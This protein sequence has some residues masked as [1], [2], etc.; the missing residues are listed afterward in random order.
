MISRDHVMKAEL[1]EHFK[2]SFILMYIN[3]IALA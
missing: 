2:S 3:I 1:A